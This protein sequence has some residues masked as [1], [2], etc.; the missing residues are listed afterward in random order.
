MC[1]LQC[2]TCARRAVDETP[3]GRGPCPSSRLPLLCVSLQ[4]RSSWGIS[5]RLQRTESP[6]STRTWRWGR[7]C[8]GLALCTP[9]CYHLQRNCLKSSSTHMVEVKRH[10]N[11]QMI[12]SYSF[13]LSLIYSLPLSLSLIYSLPLSLVSF[14]LSL[15]LSL[16]TYFFRF[17]FV[18]QLNAFRLLLL[19]VA[20]L[21]RSAVSSYSVS[22]QTKAWESALCYCWNI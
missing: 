11:I 13:C 12:P 19:S 22:H 15:C 14:P 2:A 21:F 6:S 20:S 8:A 7:E 5:R 4:G 16:S 10:L 9:V 18:F 17:S 1:L 3:H